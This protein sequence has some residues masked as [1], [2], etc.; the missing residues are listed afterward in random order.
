MAIKIAQTKSGTSTLASTVITWNSNT[1]SGNLI[2]VAVAANLTNDVSTITDSQGNNYVKAFGAAGT[3]V[4]A[5][6]WYAQNILGGATPTVTVN[7]TSG[8]TAA[9]VIQ[10][11]SGVDTLTILDKTA[12]SAGSGTALDSTPTT[13][14]LQFQELLI[15]VGGLIS[16]TFAAGG[17][18]V[19]LTQ[20]ANATINVAIEDLLVTSK[21]AYNAT[22]TGSPSG[23]WACGIASLRAA[24]QG[25]TTSVS[26]TSSTSSS[27]SST[28]SSTSST[29]SSISSTSRSTST[30]STS[31]S[32]SITTM[33]TS[34]T[35]TSLS[36]TSSS[37]T[38]SS[39]S[40]SST[41][42]S[43]SSTSFS[44]TSLSSTSSSTS[45]SSTSSSISSTSSSISSTS[46]STS[47]TSFS[48][49]SSSSSTSTTAI[50][51]NI[52]Y[53]YQDKAQF[54]VVQDIV[55]TGSVVFP[56]D[57]T[58]VQVEVWAAGGGGSNNGNDGGGG[59]GGAYSRL[60]AFTVTPGT[61]YTATVGIGGVST[62]TGGDSWFS[63]TGT[64]L[65]KGGVGNALTTGAAGGSSGGG[66]GDVTR[67]GGNGGDS[68]G[69][70]AGGA[71]GGGGA[72]GSL[73][74]GGNGVSAGAG[75]ATA[76]AGGPS[77]AAL[78]GRGGTGGSA[79]GV[80]N[81]GLTIGGG[82]GGGSQ[83]AAGGVGANGMI[84]LTYTTTSPP[85]LTSTNLIN[86]FTNA[87]YSDVAGDDGDYFIEY[88]SEY[89][90]R[91][92]KYDWINN[93]DSPQFTW[94]GRSTVDTRVSPILIQIFNVNSSTWE[95]LARETRVPADIDFSVTV[96]QTANVSNYYDS[97]NVVTFRSY[98]L[99]V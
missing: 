49:T 10:E 69:T 33:S 58:S 36:S 94:R 59:G 52:I 41:S 90:I 42:S 47:S 56:A 75:S 73:T 92:Y 51:S 6:L 80:G 65:A 50:P 30:S 74:N 78:G 1:V 62:A 2:V 91:E 83:G 70:G 14:T 61:S 63:S 28:S 4:G 82:A 5:E 71:G 15:G 20:Q 22:F 13:Q 31:S 34:S 60:N 67:S 38:S 79:A 44:S 32:Y 8:A 85:P 98:Q 53:S 27:I 35:S 11:Y 7:Y 77:G 84:R 43:I 23:Q 18:F 21:G 95:T 12:T 64:V 81:P 3:G 19:N 96:T 48:S 9:V 26:S 46:A 99:V 87:I 68:S 55:K 57:V 54:T 89:M 76:G 66:V 97:N 17:S 39:T 25:T 16:G 24:P 37:S 40:I 88:G 93:T 29:S 45:I 72:A 86:S